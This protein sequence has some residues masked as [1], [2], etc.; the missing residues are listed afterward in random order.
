MRDETDHEP[1]AA[2]PVAASAPRGISAW[3][4]G[5]AALAVLGLFG[6]WLWLVTAQDP[7]E[8]PVIAAMEGPAR[9]AAE[10]PESNLTPHRDASV[11]DAA[12]ASVQRESGGTTLA[13]PPAR[14]TGEDLAPRQI[15]AAL[16]AD[17]DGPAPSEQRGADLRPD[18]APPAPADAPPRGD[19]AATPGEP[20]SPRGP[21]PPADTGSPTAPAAVPVVAARPVHLARR[22]RAASE[23]AVAETVAL[24]E[25]AANSPWQIQL[26]AFRDPRVTRE[27]WQLISGAHASLLGGR[28]LAVQETTS[29]GETF[30]RLRVGPFESATEAE[31][32]CEA[33][34][35]RGQTCI[36]AEN[37]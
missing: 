12:V 33:L 26:G 1:E 35:A 5:L 25:R 16:G 18:A 29:G 37:R 27:Q 30:Y 9:V 4:G 28:A 21:V 15:A 11:Y 19:D 7:S 3:A 6:G 8:V 32:L 20:V 17:T 24:A 22:M 13:P 23:E 31:N 2:V 14:P 36:T 10:E 34:Q